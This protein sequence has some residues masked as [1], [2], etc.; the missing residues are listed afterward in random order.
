V[1]EPDLPLS[2]DGVLVIVGGGAIDAAL[3]RELAAAGAHLVGA[4]GGGDVIAAAGL[5][6]E[7]IIGDLDSLS[8]PAGWETRARVVHVAE[9]DT[10][11]FE[12]AL[13]STRAPVTVALGMTGGRFD[14]TL[15]ALDAVL[16]HA[17]ERRIILVD[18]HDLALALT[19]PFSFAVDAGERVSIHPL[20]PV[21]FASSEGL[22]YPLDGLL[23]APGVR[24]GTSN[25]AVAGRFT[26]TPV[27]DQSPWLLI[28]DRRYL[29]PL[30]ATPIG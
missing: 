29:R 7:A 8:D 11:D 25:V 17:R 24:L 18:T 26:M 6:P 14:H 28:V 5:L 30:I 3:L 21:R 23:L 20:G 2:F 15:A 4:D 12:K 1:Q 19:E 16:R 27:P 10:T 22:L 9:Q 13:Y